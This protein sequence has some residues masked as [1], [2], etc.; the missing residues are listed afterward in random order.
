MK[1]IL[2]YSR[3][4]Y[5]S[6]G[7]P[8]ME[9]FPALKGR[10]AA[11]LVGEGSECFGF[12]DAVSSDH[13]YA[14][15][16]FIWLPEPEFEKYGE[17]VQRAYDALPLLNP[18]LSEDKESAP[19]DTVL[20][21]EWRMRCG[22]CRI[23]DFY[24]RLLGREKLPENLY[25]WL[26]LQETRLATVTNGEVFEDEEGT[27]SEI[28][29]AYLSYFPED[30]RKKKIAA[31]L[32][33]MAQSGQY[34]YGRC[35]LHGEPV[36]AL[37]AI[38]EFIQNTCS[39]VYLLN[40]KYMPYFKWMHRGMK[41]L[42]I[43]PEVSGLLEKLSLLPEQ[44]EKWEKTHPEKYRFQLNLADEKAALIEEICRLTAEELRRQGLSESPDAYLENHAPQVESRIEDEVLRLANLM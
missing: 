37:M 9:Q 25:D 29:N 23:S 42:P 19:F 12:D 38:S 17:D 18:V 35:M 13:D 27:F 31:R 33:K 39:C 5:K 21:P 36:A 3:E 2:D 1:R 22:A 16:F 20:T 44:G 7:K 40:R 10:F 26:G 8:M 28:R 32:R 4:F 41:E 11:G 43:L 24:F 34:H 14:P 30:V 6:Y 15:R